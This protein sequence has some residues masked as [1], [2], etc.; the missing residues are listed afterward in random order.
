MSKSTSLTNCLQ[1]LSNYSSIISSQPHRFDYLVTETRW[2]TNSPRFQQAGRIAE[3]PSTSN[4]SDRWVTAAR[5]SRKITFACHSLF[6]Q[7]LGWKTRIQQALPTI[8]ESFPARVLKVRNKYAQ[9]ELLG[10]GARGCPSAS[11][12][13]SSMNAKQLVHSWV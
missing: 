4:L 8:R 7:H 12:V 5:S 10:N 11:D 2:H 1:N 6:P 13:A 3:G 9:L